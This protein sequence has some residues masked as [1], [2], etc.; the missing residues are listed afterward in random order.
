MF[1][2]VITYKKKRISYS[3][4]FFNRVEPVLKRKLYWELSWLSPETFFGLFGK[5]EAI[6]IRINRELWSNNINRP[7]RIMGNSRRCCV[8]T[9]RLSIV[10]IRDWIRSNESK[11]NT[12]DTFHLSPNRKEIKFR[13]D[14][15]SIFDPT[16][17]EIITRS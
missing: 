14:L 7:R 2:I 3:A 1:Q 6:V 10:S 17:I 9:R 16:S 13:T 12:C 4:T 8:F 11:C 5:L 15:K